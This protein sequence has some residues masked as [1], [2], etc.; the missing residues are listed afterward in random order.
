[1]LKEAKQTG[2]V[3][4]VE[5]HRLLR[6]SVQWQSLGEKCP[7]KITRIGVKDVFESPTGKKN[8]FTNTNWMQ[9]ALQNA[10]SM[11]E[12]HKEI[13]LEELKKQVYEAKWNCRAVG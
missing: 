13:M 2:R 10:S 8:C 12:R 7:T 11:E 3:Y 5:E 1:M 6:T 9:R 4:T